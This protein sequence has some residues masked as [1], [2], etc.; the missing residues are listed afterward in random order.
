MTTKL[1]RLLGILAEY[2]TLEDSDCLALPP[3]AY[4]SRELHALEVERIFEKE[5]LCVGREEQIPKPGDYYCFELMGEP[6]IIVR[7]R[8]GLTRALNGVCRHRYMPVA[9]GAGNAKSLTCPYHAWSYGLDGRLLGAP[10]MKGAKRFDKDGC[11]LPQYRLETWFGFMFVNLD[12]E[13]APLAPRM[14]TLER[15]IANYRVGEQVQVLPYGA[16]WAG[17]WKF[18]A[19]NSM[20]YYHHIALHK[21]TV[22][23]QL[24]ASGTYVPPP[25][26]DRSFTHERCR[27]G[28]E[29]RAGRSHSM[30][31]VGRLDLFTEEELTT[32]YMVYVF[33]AFTM[34]MRPNG[35]NWLSFQPDGPD[36]T[37]VLGGYLVAPEMVGENAEVVEARRRLIARV[38]EQDSL[39]TTELAKA[40]RSRKAARGPLGPFEATIAQFYKYL[41]GTLAGPRDTAPRTA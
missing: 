21:D 15:H 6:L 25:P 24:P 33:P 26:D 5:W 30:N 4:L 13:A 41:A 3:D 20:E 23:V 31:P 19:E 27:M 22:G 14:R 8:D 29:F 12:D 7:D 40:I 34:A 36:R 35:N 9:Q 39:A 10:Y 18:A 2:S 28:D 32:G 38:N 17:N 1:D 37:K 16:E 11:R